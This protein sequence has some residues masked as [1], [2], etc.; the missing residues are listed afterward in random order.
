M[1]LGPRI[2]NLISKSFDN[3]TVKDVKDV[4]R[5]VKQSL[6]GKEGIYQ[7][8][9]IVQNLKKSEGKEV[10]V[11]FDIGAAVGDTARPLLKAFPKAD[12]YC[13]EP[14]ADSFERLKHRTAKHGNRAKHFNFGLYNRNGDIDF[15]IT[16]HRES[17]SI[18]NFN[19][20]HIADRIEKI[21]IRRLDD[22]VREL[23]VTHID[24][25]KID[26][27]G[28]E[29]ELLEGA[30]E[31]LAITDTIFVE[32]SP[33]RKGPHNHDYIDVFEY[34][35]QAGFSLYGIMSDFLFTKLT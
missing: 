24:F 20:G 28:A 4:L 26:V 11:V 31:T 32:I 5:P 10:S 21:E 2:Y 25:M 15:Y 9:E 14:F 18:N 6:V 7:V 17:N 1:A 13:F 3:D 16:D 12:V 34:L 19:T 30:K 8:I 22:V 35:H 23:G 27:E 33:L 29:K